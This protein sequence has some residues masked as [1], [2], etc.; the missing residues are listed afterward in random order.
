MTDNTSPHNVSST[1]APDSEEYLNIDGSFK[2]A[3][4]NETSHS[5]DFFRFLTVRY[6]PGDYT[7]VHIDLKYQQEIKVRDRIRKFLQG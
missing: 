7:V 2:D 5:N 3:D 4:G 1:S 6:E